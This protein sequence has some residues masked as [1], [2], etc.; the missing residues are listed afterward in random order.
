MPI[1]KPIPIRLATLRTFGNLLIDRFLISIRFM[2]A[3]VKHMQTRLILLLAK[4]QNPRF[5]IKGIFRRSIFEIPPMEEI[6]H[7]CIIHK[8]LMTQ[9]TITNHIIRNLITMTNIGT[10]LIL[11]DKVTMSIS[12][13]LMDEDTMPIPIPIPTTHTDKIINHVLVLAGKASITSPN[14]ITIRCFLPTAVLRK[15]VT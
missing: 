14:H 9:A 11:M 7:S 3:I 13:I 5:K 4:T 1:P 15:G 12:L 2:A 6:Q 8:T 10:R